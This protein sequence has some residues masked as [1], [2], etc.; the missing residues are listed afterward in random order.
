VHY[1]RGN[2]YFPLGRIDECLS[3]HEQSRTIAQ[4]EG[5]AEKEARALGGMGDA[6]YQR[7]R[8][9]GAGKL[10]DACI[11]LSQ[12]HGFRE[13]EAAHLP[14]RGLTRFFEVRFQ[15]G[16]ED[17]TAGAILAEATGQMR[18]QLVSHQVLSYLLAEMERHEEAI[19]ASEKTIELSRILGATNLETS[20]M[21]QMARSLFDIGR[22]PEAIT[23]ARKAY[24]MIRESGLA[25]L[26]PTVLGN[27]AW[28][29]D[30]E[31]ERSKALREGEALLGQNSVSHNYARFYRFAAEVSLDTGQWR[32]AE[33]YALALENYFR[34]EPLPWCEIIVDRARALAAHGRGNRGSIMFESL[35]RLRDR[36]KSRD[37]N[38]LLGAI[39]IALS[40]CD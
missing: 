14:M 35:V 37:F 38:S 13:I 27:L 20:A 18:A 7:G 17:C 10:F 2:L 40:R 26:G 28:I 11:E 32:E 1:L 15:E 23:L 8:I 4:R 30:V 5:L 9:I 24:Q 3:E 16:R 22:R 12:K 25:F 31:D 39:E 34:P 36:A 19:A 6:Y 33:R 21:T 29:T